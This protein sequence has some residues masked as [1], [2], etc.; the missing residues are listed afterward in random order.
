M[1]KMGLKFINWEINF[2][3]GDYNDIVCFG[4]L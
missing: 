2:F 3:L 1:V 4:L